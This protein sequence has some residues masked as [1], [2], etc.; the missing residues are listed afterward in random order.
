MCT[1]RIFIINI[2]ENSNLAVSSEILNIAKGAIIRPITVEPV[3][4]PSPKGG[5][6]TAISG[7]PIFRGWVLFSPPSAREVGFSE[8]EPKVQVG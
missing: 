8:L 3:L 7:E 4:R 6:F 5:I 2:P 1:R